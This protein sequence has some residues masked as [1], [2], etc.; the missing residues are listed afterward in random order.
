MGIDLLNKFKSSNSCGPLIN[1]SSRVCCLRL[2][3]GLVSNWWQRLR[4]RPEAMAAAAATPIGPAVNSCA[5][6]SEEFK[7]SCKGGYVFK[8]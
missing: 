3:L 4:L 2:M 8:V 6:T 5:V 7:I 1:L